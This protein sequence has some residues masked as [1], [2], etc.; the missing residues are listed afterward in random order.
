MPVPTSTL[1]T[2]KSRHHASIHNLNII[3]TPRL[4]DFNEALAPTTFSARLPSLISSLP[5]VI[6]AAEPSFPGSV[7]KIAPAASV[8]DV[9]PRQDTKT[10]CWANKMGMQQCA[11]V[12]LNG[13]SYLSIQRTFAFPTLLFKMISFIPRAL[14]GEIPATRIR[15]VAERYQPFITSFK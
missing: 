12:T 9:E 1:I 2:I 5:S 10:Y 4:A 15:N 3:F 7:E 11:T 14:A 8:P 6:A 13:G